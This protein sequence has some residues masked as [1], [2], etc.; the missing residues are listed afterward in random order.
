[1][2]TLRDTYIIVQM[3]ISMNSGVRI[4]QQNTAHCRLGRVPTLSGSKTFYFL[5]YES[6]SCKL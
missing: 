3:V 1:M 6:G 2:V 4:A 5:F